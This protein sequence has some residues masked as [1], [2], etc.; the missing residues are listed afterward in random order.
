VSAAHAR[1]TERD[2][3]IFYFPLFHTNALAW[4]MLATLASGGTAVLL[5]RFSSSRFWTLSRRYGCTWAHMVMFTLRALAQTPDPEDHSFRFWGGTG[6]LSFV[7]KRWGIK[8]IGWF[9]MTE[10][11][12]QC[13]VSSFDEIGP[14]DSMGM[15]ALEYEVAVR[16]EDGTEV[17]FG[18]TGHLWIRGIPGISLFYEYLNDPDATAHAF[19][20][21][22]WFATG[23]LASVRSSGHFFFEGRAKDMLKVGGEN[24][25]AIEIESAIAGVPGVVEVA[26]VGRADPMLDEVPVAFVVAEMPGAELEAAIHAACRRALSDFKR[27][28]EIR[29]VPQLPKGLLDKVLKKELRALLQEHNGS[30]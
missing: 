26:V 7:S 22:G 13:T 10:T 16:R 14:E 3:H 17:A 9:G 29:F 15:P 8:T 19:D 6:D 12:S 4:S 11:V 23:D 30:G 20:A 27:P 5:P 25:A 2:V 21:R 28:R 24:V 18:E 1:L